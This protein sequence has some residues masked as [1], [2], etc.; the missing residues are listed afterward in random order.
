IVDELREQIL[1][2]RFPHRVQ[3]KE[4]TP[5]TKR[6][7]VGHVSPSKSPLVHVA[8]PALSDRP[9][10]VVLSKPLE[11]LLIRYEKLPLDFR[12]PFIFNMENFLVPF[13]SAVPLS[14]AANRAASSTLASLSRY[15]LHRRWVWALQSSQGPAMTLQA[16]AHIL[17]VL[18]EIRLAEGFHFAASGEGIINMVIELPM[19]IISSDTDQ[20][21][22]SCIVQYILFPPHSTSSKD[23]FSTDDDNDTEVEAVDIDS[24]LNLITECWVEPQ[25]GSVMNC[26][27]QHRH[28]Q[29]LKYQDIPQAIFPR[30]LACMSTMM[31]F[32]YLNQ[33]CQNKDQ[34][35][36]LPTAHK[37]VQGEVPVSEDS[38]HMVPF[39][40][41]LIQLLPNCQQVELFFLTF[42]TGVDN[43]DQIHSNSTLP[44]ELLLSLFHTSLEQ[45]L[46]DREVPLAAADYAAFM[47]HIL[48]R[49]RDGH[50]A[51]FAWSLIKEECL[52]PTYRK[53]TTG[54]STEFMGSTSTLQS[55][56][57]ADLVDEELLERNS[58]VPHWR[59][60]AKYIN[61]QQLLLTFLPATFADVLL[62]MA[63]ALGTE[64]RNTVSTQEDDTLT[65]STRSQ[66][67]SPS[68]FT[69][70]PDR[71]ESG[72]SVSSKLHRSS[73]CGNFSAK[74]SFLTPLSENHT[75]PV[76]FLHVDL[77]SRLSETDA[78]T[79]GSDPG[80]KEGVQF[81]E[82]QKEPLHI[83]LTSQVSQQSSS[84]SSH[85]KCPVYVYN[86]SLEHLKEQ[87]VHPNSCCQPKDIFFRAELQRSNDVHC[88]SV[89]TV[90]A[91]EGGPN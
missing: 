47:N 42:N 44:N 87:L 7:T 84:D 2:L 89:R 64:P 52:K 82:P 22:H 16:I 4:A 86:C 29:G 57:N 72:Y 9:C 36:S 88:K 39:Q 75:G 43:E 23:S 59:C 25:S 83:S 77:D 18:S 37:V 21:S 63:S 49:E 20:E 11:K 69:S 5:K 30:D 54:S 28:F 74:S 60:Y 27:D 91:A 17:S 79:P 6:K 85:L 35:C 41:D 31:T 34:I 10:V 40:F 3:N 45:E 71:S 38:I 33:L 24:E 55:F 80:G 78:G 73:S 1:K 66:A 65:P 13:N 51:P 19:K 68:G 8:K 61:T 48:E 15:L 26:M 58:S 81:S 76:D 14:M 56:S 12:T 53:D 50:V 62:L 70:G 90:L 67:D 32:E 46:S